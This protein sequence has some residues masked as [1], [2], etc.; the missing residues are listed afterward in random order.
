M[1]VVLNVKGSFRTTGSSYNGKVVA[2]YRWPLEQVPLY[3]CTCTCAGRSCIKT[4][5]VLL[6]RS[7]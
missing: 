7:Y 1:Q 4:T 2:L 3:S 6:N 5:H